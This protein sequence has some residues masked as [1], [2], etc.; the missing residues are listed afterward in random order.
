MSSL[1][2]LLTTLAPPPPTEVLVNIDLARWPSSGVIQYRLKFTALYRQHLVR[3]LDW[4][5]LQADLLC[6]RIRALDRALECWELVLQ[7]RMELEGSWTFPTLA[8]QRLEDLRK[9]LGDEDYFAGR[10]PPLPDL[11]DF[12]EIK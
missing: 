3:R 8:A 2:L 9:K 4:D 10:L 12:S 7:A 6:G 1:L 5:L 11:V